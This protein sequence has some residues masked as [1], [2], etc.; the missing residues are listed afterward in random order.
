MEDHSATAQLIAL[1]VLAVTLFVAGEG[2]LYQSSEAK[3]YSSDATVA[4]LLAWLA[5]LVVDRETDGLSIPALVIFRRAE[6]LQHPV[7]RETL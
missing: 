1:A 7:A 2:L 6:S 5:L 3:P 4:L